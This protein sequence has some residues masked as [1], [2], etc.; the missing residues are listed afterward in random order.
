MNTIKQL[1]KPEEERRIFAS[2]VF[3]LLILLMLFSHG[4]FAADI[5]VSLDRNPVN[6]DESFQ[7]MFTTTES[8]DDDPDFT[9]LEQDFSI[10]NQTNS[11]SSSWVNGKSSKTV[12]WTVNVMAKHLGSLVIP[13]IKFGKDVSNSSTVL[14][15][16]N[17]I[18]KTV[19]TDED[20]YI[21]VEATPENPFIQ[22]QVF[23][24]L[25]LYTK[26]D[27]SQAR[28]NEPDLADA[29]IERLGEDSNYNTQVN[30][31]NYSVT[32]RKYALFPQKSGQLTIKPLILTAEVL[33]NS[34]PSFNGFFNSQMSKTKRVESKAITLNVKPVP[35]T[36]TGKHWLSAEQL[37]LKQEWSG[38][39]QQMKVGEPLTRTLSLIAKGTTVGQLPELNT[40]ETN[41]HL[42]AYPD[43]PVLQEQKKVD[44][45]LA[46]REEKIALIP[47]KSGSYTLS[48][49]EIP[50]FNTKSQKMELAK[51]PETTL[52]TV[53]VASQ[54]EVINP[55][56]TPELPKNTETSLVIESPKKTN[57]WLW[58]SLLLAVGWLITVIVFLTKRKVTEPVIEIN[59]SNIKLKDCI[60]NLKNACRANDAAA[61]KNALL[62]WGRQKFNVANLGAIA[63]Y[64]DAR[65]RDEILD[66]NQ[67]LYGKG[68]G[69][70]QG[71]KLFQAFTENK[72]REKIA[73]T[74]D[75]SL[76]PLYR[77]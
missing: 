62:E 64:S 77:L 14:V 71:K 26:V 11:S 13:A 65:L 37:V 1:L 2:L 51:I 20:L 8:P 49:I 44:G 47:S 18:K 23:Y 73:V 32:E 74:E 45:L 7:I 9:P 4:T 17:A 43:Q 21:E 29:V 55:I 46:F 75:N 69:Q 68:V 35:T 25:R 66:L 54:S 31:L 6:L 67:T 42:K 56:I 10:L 19:N 5:T 34:R 16:D 63:E 76:E 41:D 72:A 12:L 60:K 28:L 53:A 57:I 15:A 61:T 40:T 50:W 36:F 27:I 3:F 24:T 58:V 30:G 59:D 22:S 39:I 38:D 70:W 48:A 52:S 33:T